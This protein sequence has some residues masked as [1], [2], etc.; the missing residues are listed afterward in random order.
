MIALYRL[1]YQEGGSAGAGWLLG[2]L[3][4]AESA[5]RKWG[6]EQQLGRMLQV[7]QLTFIKF[8]VTCERRQALP[9]ADAPQYS[10][11]YHSMRQKVKGYKQGQT[12]CKE[13]EVESLSSSEDEP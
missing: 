1:K 13:R 3:G 2:S 9:D 4:E 11:T 6:G 10:Q 8:C 5:I 12:V 7:L